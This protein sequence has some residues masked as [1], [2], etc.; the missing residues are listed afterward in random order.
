MLQ[1]DH[2]INF[3]FKGPSC[4]VIGWLISFVW[5]GKGLGTQRQGQISTMFDSERHIH[6]VLHTGSATSH[7]DVVHLVWGQTKHIQQASRQL[8]NM[9]EEKL[10]MY[11][12]ELMHV[13]FSAI[14]QSY[15]LFSKRN[16][17]LIRPFSL[18]TLGIGAC[19]TWPRVTWPLPRIPGKINESILR[20]FSKRLQSR[21]L[22]AT[23]QSLHP[24]FRFSHRYAH[25]E[26]VFMKTGNL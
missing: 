3:F 9:Y 20:F 22:R 13:D 24:I 26:N 6:T 15:T 5:F 2:F 1:E 14:S 21:S 4:L 10:F 12:T 23:N 19:L 17:S 16:A 18:V 7:R 25:I 11:K 8:D